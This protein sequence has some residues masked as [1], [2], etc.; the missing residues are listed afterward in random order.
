MSS[1]FKYSCFFKIGLNYLK[2]YPCVQACLLLFNRGKVLAVVV[3]VQVQL[4]VPEYTV[5]HL[6]L[7]LLTIPL[8]GQ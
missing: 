3:A 7:Y 5:T 6:L 8:C 4:L 2:S 1:N